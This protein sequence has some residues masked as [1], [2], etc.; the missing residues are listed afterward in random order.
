MGLIGFMFILK[1]NVRALIYNGPSGDEA[2]EIVQLTESNGVWSVTVPRSWEGYYYV[3]E[4][5]VYHP[6]TL[7][8]EKCFANDPYA[9]GYV[10]CVCLCKCAHVMFLCLFSYTIF[11]CW[12]FC[13]LSSDGKRTFLVNV[14]SD[15]LKPPNWDNLGDEKPDIAEFS[16]ISI[17]ELHIRDFRCAN[18]LLSRKAE[19]KKNNYW[20]CLFDSIQRQ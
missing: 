6:S 10:H 17:Y 20:D 13:R 18:I 16:D 3:Y 19:Y 2:L 14:D 5:S 9:R 8:I 11:S 7:Q 15:A 1:Q 12:A 4:V